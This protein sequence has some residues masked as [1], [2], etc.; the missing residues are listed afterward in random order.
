MPYTSYLL[1]SFGV[2]PAFLSIEFIGARMQGIKL[3]DAECAFKRQT[4]RNMSKGC[5]KKIRFRA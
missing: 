4:G 2:L 1:T 3:V 5:K